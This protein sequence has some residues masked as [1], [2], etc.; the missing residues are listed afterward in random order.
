M[1]RLGHAFARLVVLFGIAFVAAGL[2]A[3]QDAL[4]VVDARETHQIMRG[5]EVTARAWETNKRLDRFDPSWEA[6]RDELVERLVTELGINRIRI[7]IKSGVENPVDYWALFRAGKIGYREYVRHYYEKINDN[8]DPQVASPAGFQFSAL[9]YQVEKM[10]LP[11][12]RRLADRGERLYVNLCY[13]DFGGARNSGLSHARNPEEYAELVSTAFEHLAARYGFTPDAVEIVLEPENTDD[14]RGRQI[15]LAMVAAA[16]RL[17][18]AGYAPDF[19]APSTTAA[20]AAPRYFD[21]MMK[22]PGA[23]SV[24]SELAYHR[25]RDLLPDNAL[26]AIERRARQFG[27]RTAMLEHIGGDVSEL[28]AD[29]T[30]A[31]ASAWQQYGIAAELL[32]QEKDRGAYYYVRDASEGDGSG[33]R[34]AERTRGL[35]QYFRFIRAG[36]VRIGATT[37]RAHVLPVAFRNPDGTTVVVAQVKDAANLQVRGLPAGAYGSRYTTDRETGRELPVV[38]LVPGEALT[39][40]VPAPGVITFYQKRAG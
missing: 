9:D 36:A 11:L 40:R 39:A 37:S 22:V 6:H 14:W 21:E 35:A 16:R 24:I 30:I 18:R 20:S 29:L 5:W 12:A 26:P 27:L 15:G 33:I 38:R 23:S 28:H 7:E 3:E 17:Q 31:D 1:K 2:Y 19:I 13:V 8:D 4:I 32:P 25:Y 10:V 34:M